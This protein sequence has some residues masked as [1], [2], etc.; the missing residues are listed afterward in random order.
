MTTSKSTIHIMKNILTLA[1]AFIGSSLLY[2]CTYTPPEPPDDP[3]NPRTPPVAGNAD[4]S[5]Y[6]AVG[7]S[8][9]AGFMDNALYLEGQ[10]NAY[11]VILADRM[12]SVNGNAAFNFP[13]YGTAGGAGFG[14][15]FV[16]GTATPIGRYQFELPACKSNTNQT[17][18]LGLTP[19]PTI[20]GEPLAPYTGNKSELNNFGVPGA[21]IF[22]ALVPG[23]GVSP[24]AGNPF[25]WRFASAATASL[26]GDAVAAK[27][28][29][30][31][32]WLGN[33]DVLSYAT[34]GGSGNPN[35]GTNPAAYGSND[36]TD[37]LV[38]AVVL[39]NSLDAL[40]STGATTKGAIATIPNVVNIPYFRLINSGLTTGG[41]NAP[42]P[43]NL[44]ASQAAALN[45]GYALLG[46][47]A[48]GVNFKP[49]KVNYPV[50][51]TATGL[52]HLD[53]TKDFLTLVTP[54]DSLLA[55]PIS[56]CN[57]APRAGWGITKPIP[58]H[59]VLDQTEVDLVT[60]R[61]TAYNNI[62]R[63]EAASR[64]N[65]L[66]LVDIQLFLANL[67]ARYNTLAPPFGYFSLDGV[68]PN[69]RGQAAIA[70]EFIKAINAKFNATLPPVNLANYR[71]NKLP[72]Q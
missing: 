31:T 50:I 6:V 27:G 60:Q 23:Y 28:T 38:F 53:P 70:N 56:V 36:M 12:K 72:V 65:L 13:A 17:K 59:Y 2:S 45:A 32:Y 15:S 4:F 47:A 42:L 21:K 37:P 16:P 26:L 62:I 7:N 39:K 66:A 51:T 33:N 49:G 20:P 71:L 11:P 29:F 43:F 40:F 44:S 41:V 10:Q 54:Q 24:V 69:P 55:G 63:Q 22:H 67:D 57:I 30:F 46:P 9:T 8:L 68:H 64:P 19:A 35:P 5:K 58:A 52:K 25:F 18:T 48:A 61:V 3:T 1:L 14:G 34:S